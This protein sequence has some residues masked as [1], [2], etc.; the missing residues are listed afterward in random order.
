MHVAKR[1]VL[2]VNYPCSFVKINLHSVFSVSSIICWVFLDKSLNDAD[3]ERNLEKV[4]SVK[5]VVFVAAFNVIDKNL[6]WEEYLTK[7]A[8]H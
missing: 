7:L 1:L 8:L 5:S 4:G 3:G 6:S 2:L